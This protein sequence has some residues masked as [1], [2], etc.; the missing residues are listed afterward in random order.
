MIERARGHA[1]AAGLG[2]AEFL[3]ADAQIHPF[4][5]S[6]FDQV[7]SRTGA[8]FFGDLVAAFS[9]VAQ[10]LRRSGRLTPLVWQDDDH[11]PWVGEFLRVTTRRPHRS[12]RCG[13]PV[14]HV[15][16][17]REAGMTV[18]SDQ[19]RASRTR[20]SMF[21]GPAIHPPLRGPSCPDAIDHNSPPNGSA[22]RAG[23]IEGIAFYR[24]TFSDLD[25][26]IEQEL[27]TG[28]L[29][30]IYGRVNGVH[31]GDTLG[32]P[33]TGRQVSFP[34][35]DI[36]RIT[37]GPDGGGL[38]YRRYCRAGPSG[39]RIAWL[40]AEVSAAVIRRQ[41]GTGRSPQRWVSLPDRDE[42]W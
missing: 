28:D 8:M 15:A 35:I 10:A 20:S 17:C 36:F 14:C 18:M 30:A 27:E 5:A 38:A 42:R 32:I 12:R 29:V 21:S 7:I 26:T 23:L 22:G 3:Q 1:A 39:R 6:S 2:N 34:Y 9:N 19:T 24:A 31:T 11:N 37:E 13:L 4:A 40:G 41:C 25:V 16:Y 33:A